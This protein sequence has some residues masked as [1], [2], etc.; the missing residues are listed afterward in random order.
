VISG[1]PSYEA[2]AGVARRVAT[3]GAVLLKNDGALPLAASVK[4]ILVVGGHADLGVT[5]GGGSSQVIPVGGPA[6]I[7]PMGGGNPFDAQVNRQILTGS[8]PL[9]AL[10]ASLPNTRIDYDSGYARETAAVRAARADMVIVFATRWQT[11]GQ[12]APGLSLPEGQDELISALAAANHNTVVLLETGNPVAMPW[13]PQVR[14]VLEAW[15]PGQAGGLAIADLL[16]G[17]ANPSG[18]LPIT[19]PRS[20]SQAPRPTPPGL[21]LPEESRIPITY[22][23]GADVG[24]R[25]FAKRG[26]TPLFAFGHGLSYTRFE[27]GPLVLAAGATVT[28]RARVV[29]VGAVEGA[30]TPQLYLV[31]AGGRPVLR[32]AA[33][34]KPMLKPGEGREVSFTVDPR[35]LADWAGEGWRIAPGIYGFALGRS[36][37]ELGPV[38]TVRLAER[39]LKP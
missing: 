28:A 37:T 14:S 8:S 16:T 1:A 19:F 9:A 11:E 38:A 35:I 25:G 23:E 36:A 26:Q 5:S 2:D 13:L 27:H 29:N 10:R 34:A 3:A 31:S 39:R 4:S 18:R 22:G 30:D 17:R 12:D 21:G 7:I 15:Y 24:Y 20:E 33:F 32:L 6:A